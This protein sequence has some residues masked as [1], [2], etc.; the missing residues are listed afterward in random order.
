MSTYDISSEELNS[1]TD[2]YYQFGWQ[3]FTLGNMFISE[4]FLDLCEF[5]G[6]MSVLLVLWVSA[7]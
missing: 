7:Q 6:C 5:V 3:I 4:V 1:L 2:T